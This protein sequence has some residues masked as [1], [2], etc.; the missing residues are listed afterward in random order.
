MSMVLVFPQITLSDVYACVAS[1]GLDIDAFLALTGPRLPGSTGERDS[2]FV[3]S[4]FLSTEELHDAGVDTI[5]KALSAKVRAGAVLA[6][7]DSRAWTGL[8]A[9]ARKRPEWRTA[10]VIQPVGVR[11]LTVRMEKPGWDF[12]TMP[13]DSLGG[14]GTATDLLDALRERIRPTT[15]G[16]EYLAPAPAIRALVVL[17]TTLAAVLSE[18]VAL[19]SDHRRG[20]RLVRPDIYEAAVVGM[21]LG[22]HFQSV[23]RVLEIDHPEHRPVRAPWPNPTD[24]V[25]DL[26][27]L[28]YRGQREQHLTLNAPPLPK[29]K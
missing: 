27:I 23:R 7:P 21:G 17:A 12:R 14:A 28:E 4:L 2:D 29:L 9:W 3:R 19:K 20:V 1:L 16:A 24:P 25:R 8:A 11:T 6:H 26:G 22:E 18:P 10:H 13:S 15:G 5:W